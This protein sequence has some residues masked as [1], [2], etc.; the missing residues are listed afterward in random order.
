MKQGRYS[1][2]RRRGIVP[3]CGGLAVLMATGAVAADQPTGPTFDLSLKF[4]AGEV[5]RYRLAVQVQARLPAMGV[6]P[7]ASVYDVN[8]DLVEQ[9]KVVRVLPDGG[10]IAVST[11]SGQGTTNGAPFTPA[12]DKRPVLITFSTRGDLV[13]VKDLPSANSGVPMLSNMF[14]SGALSMNGVFLPDKPVRIGDIWSKK[15]H[16][17]GL[18]GSGQ[19]TVKATLVK[20]EEVGHYKTAVIHTV[21]SAP[22][23]TMIDSTYQPTT[24]TRRAISIVTGTF[25]MAYDTNL[26]IAEGKV[27]RAT[28]SGEVIVLIQPNTPT[29]P[30]PA[31]GKPNSPNKSKGTV[32]AN[33]KAAPATNAV[34]STKMVMELHMGNTLIQ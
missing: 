32:V 17:A 16:I 21:L 19:A 12:A 25:N 30:L 1:A 15:V 27:I 3:L 26:A 2:G 6:Q 33:G 22:L 34:T 24:E 20:T 10:E 4:K 14:G 23:R 31:S 29:A 18:T 11:L 5:S 8:V 9:E 13:A 7:S 28:G